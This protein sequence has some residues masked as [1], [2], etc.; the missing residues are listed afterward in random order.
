ME[1]NHRKANVARLFRKSKPTIRP[2]RLFN[3]DG[4]GDDM[5]VLWAAYKL[6]SFPL[7][8][9]QDMTPDEFG[10][11]IAGLC[12]GMTDAVIAEDDN[13]RYSSG[14]GPIAFIGIRSDGWRHEPH[15][16]YF[17]WATRRNIL[18]TTVGFL[19]FMRYHKQVG[20]CIVRCLDPHVALFRRANEYTLLNY[21]GRIVNG[22]PRGDEHVFTVAGKKRSE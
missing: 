7:L 10:R 3:E 4:Y 11:H 12:F 9:N 16:D 19:R 13:T 6:G 20:V 18:R 2:A 15:V 1:A 21:L 14:R 5:G 22:T 17:R 8:E